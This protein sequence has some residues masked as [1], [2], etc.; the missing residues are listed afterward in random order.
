MPA[1]IERYLDIR[2]AY[3]ASFSPDG[4]L[5]FLLTTTGTP[6]VWSLAE[7]G[8]WPEQRTFF[9]ERVTFASF[10]PEREELIFGMDEG[11][12]ERAQLFRL[13]DSRVTPLTDK[14]D[15]K[16]RWGGWSHD[17]EQFAFAANRR[18]RSVF[19]IYVQGRDETEEEATRVYEGDGWFT[20]GGFSPSDDRLLVSESHSSFDHDLSVLDLSGDIEHVTPHEGDVRYQSAAWGPA[21]DA[22]YV[23]TD[24]NSD[25]L[26]LARLDIATHEL[27][28]VVDDPEWNVEGFALDE[29]TGRLVYARNVNGYTDLTVGRL[30]GETEIEE[31]P[32]PALP[33]GIAGSIEF[34]SDAERFA[35]TVTGP[36][37]NTNVHVVDV[38][39]GESECWTRASTAGFSREHFREPE[40]VRYETFDDREIPAFFSLPADS[41]AGET[42]VVVDIHGGPEAQRRPRFSPVTQYLLDAGYG[43]FEPN[44]RG[45]TGYGKTYTH[46][47]DRE[48]R[49]DSVADIES[50]VEWLSNHSMVDTDRIAVMGGSYGGFMTLAALTEYP[51]LW[52]AGVDIV[53]I[54]DFTTFL[55]NTGSWR[56]ALREAEYGSLA[57]DRAMLESISPLSRIE[58]IDA[59][60]FVLHGANDPRVPVGEAEQVAERV[61]EQDIPVETMIFEDEGHG[62]VK[63]DNR[64]D[65]YTEI[66]R[67]LDE[68]V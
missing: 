11:G 51:D 67:F 28:P 68:H 3:G 16:H 60:L 43:V 29:G 7:A 6:Q 38:E 18:D 1:A 19:D 22:L 2:S 52:A 54:A 25:T 49:M 61:R 17:G 63:R 64:I 26:Y 21:G 47:D 56:R 31:F 5:V 48:H 59:P 4:E 35:V 27:E 15:A 24:H 34:D 41:R 13:A 44:V 66:A 30:A 57:D 23:V 46:L 39:T 32:A 14:P 10:S 40:L 20:V 42:P 53:G 9:D 58:R 12:N 45:S 65:A 33:D 62:I 55:E 36:R 8:A 50:G 37:E